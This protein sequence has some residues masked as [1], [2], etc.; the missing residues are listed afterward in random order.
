MRKHSTM[1]LPQTSIFAALLLL[2]LTITA[3]TVESLGSCKCQPNQPCWPSESDWQE[4]NST[5]GGMLIGDIRPIS[6]ACYKGTPDHNEARCDEV[7][8]NFGADI[9]RANQSGKFHSCHIVQLQADNRIRC[10]PTHHLGN[11]PPSG[12]NLLPPHAP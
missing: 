5:V 7:T 2:P 1:K 11:L 12:R 9:W 4:L 3:S 8:K 10:R 6:S